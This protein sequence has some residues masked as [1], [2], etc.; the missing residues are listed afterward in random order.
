MYK[1]KYNQYIPAAVATKASLIAGAIIEDQLCLTSKF[2]EW[3]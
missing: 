2:G 1:P 3:S